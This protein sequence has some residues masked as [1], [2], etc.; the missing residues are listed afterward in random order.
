[1]FW[2]EGG[3]AKVNS[4]MAHEAREA[5]GVRTKVVSSRKERTRRESSG[6]LRLP[7]IQLKAAREKAAPPDQGGIYMEVAEAGPA[8]R[9]RLM[10]AGTTQWIHNLRVKPGTG[11]GFQYEYGRCQ[12]VIVLAFELGLS[13]HVLLNWR[14]RQ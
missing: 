7:V 8:S 4:M 12:I 5:N 14:R 11:K 9:L 13:R 10:R 2:Q 6:A 1:M 3:A